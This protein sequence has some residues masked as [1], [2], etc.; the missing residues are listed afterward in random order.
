MVARWP[1]SRMLARAAPRPPLRLAWEPRCARRRDC[2]AGARSSAAAPAGVRSPDRND[3]ARQSADD[4]LLANKVRLWQLR[5]EGR[6][7]TWACGFVIPE[8]SSKL[9]RCSQ[10]REIWPG[11]QPRSAAWYSGYLERTMAM[12]SASSPGL[13]AWTFSSGCDRRPAGGGAVGSGSGGLGLP[14]R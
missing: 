9:G 13:P 11:R 6:F 7:T 10:D 2:P 1:R 14:P 4:A 5:G 8:V 3:L 12:L